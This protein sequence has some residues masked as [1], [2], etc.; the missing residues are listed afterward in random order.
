[1]FKIKYANKKYQFAV[2]GQTGKVVGSLPISKGVS[3]A[4]FLLRFGI[5][6]GAIMLASLISYLVGGA[7]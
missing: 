7:F 3:R 5:V 2:N 6:A 4:Y 1:M